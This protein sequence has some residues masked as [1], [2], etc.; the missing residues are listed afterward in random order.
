MSANTKVR[1]TVTLDKDVAAAVAKFRRD[2]DLGLSEA[3]NDL[4]RAGL[5]A[6]KERK[7]FVQKTFDAGLKVDITHIGEAL[8]QAEGPWYR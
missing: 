7:P 1:T 3:V 6:P 4:I 5:I 2:K 8:E